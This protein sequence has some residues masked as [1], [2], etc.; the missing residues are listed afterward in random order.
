MA[1]KEASKK[2]VVVV[3]DHPIVRQGIVQMISDDAGLEVVGQAQEVAAGLKLIQ[4]LSPDMAIVDFTLK[5]GT[6]VDLMQRLAD[7]QLSLP[8]LVF[9]MHDETFYAERALRAGA[10]GYVTKAESSDKLLA[11]VRKVLEG[12]VYVSEKIAV[13]MLHG[14]VNPS[15]EGGFPIDSLSDREKEIFTYIGE[16]METRHIADQLGLSTK[17]VESHRENIKRKL[18]ID[19]ATEL[20]QRAIH[21]VRFERKN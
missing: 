10:K 21:W 9:S 12:Q 16:G 17:T 11:G 5:D 8:I 20:L 7:A 4:D 2:R 3:E 19:N 6:C 13:K 1:K 15:R 18:K 14:M